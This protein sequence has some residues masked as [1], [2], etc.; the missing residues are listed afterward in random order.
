[1]K[2][3]NPNK[4][5]QNKQ[6]TKFDEYYKKA[7]KDLEEFIKIQREKLLNSTGIPLKYYENKD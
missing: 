3:N 6:L 7:M 5:Y 1:M 2:V 4:V